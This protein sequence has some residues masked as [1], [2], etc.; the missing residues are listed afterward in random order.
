MMNGEMNEFMNIHPYIHVV[1]HA[2]T[3]LWEMVSERNYLGY[4]G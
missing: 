2:C 4:F 3:C 1:M